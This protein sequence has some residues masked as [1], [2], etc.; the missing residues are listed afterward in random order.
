MIFA[1]SLASGKPLNRV[2]MLLLGINALG[3]LIHLSSVFSS[4]VMPDLLTASE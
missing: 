2:P 1:R 4:Q 3:F